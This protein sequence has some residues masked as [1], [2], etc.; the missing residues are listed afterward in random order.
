[1]FWN[2]PRPKN[3]SEIHKIKASVT[4]QIREISEVEA[5]IFMFKSKFLGFV[6]I[7]NC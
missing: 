3:E 6:K 7:V 1:M 5:E 4:K 2:K